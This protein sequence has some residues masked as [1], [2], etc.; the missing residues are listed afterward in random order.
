VPQILIVD[1]ILLSEKQPADNT[2]ESDRKNR[3]Q[4]LKQWYVIIDGHVDHKRAFR[5]EI[6]SGRDNDYDPHQKKGSFDYEPGR[7]GRGYPL[8]YVDL[9][10]SIPT[11]KRRITA[12]PSPTP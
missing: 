10:F 2:T 3:L 12:K 5:K 7:P 4:E 6:S 1:S 11:K 9:H 8:L